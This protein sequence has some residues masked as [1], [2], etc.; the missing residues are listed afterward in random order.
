[1]EGLAAEN[2]AEAGALDC[3]DEIVAFPAALTV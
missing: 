2:P 3:A 1:M